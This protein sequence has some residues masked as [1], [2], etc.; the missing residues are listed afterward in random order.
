M[1]EEA[2]PN[3]EEEE[4]SLLIVEDNLRFAETLGTEL[5]DR[6]YAVQH[7]DCLSAVQEADIEAFLDGL[8]EFLQ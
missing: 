2:P 1:A 4:R 3:A 5:S 8:T 7:A 6:G